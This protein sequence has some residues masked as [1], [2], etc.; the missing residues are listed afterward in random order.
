MKPC[1]YNLIRSEPFYRRD[2]FTAGLKACGFDVKNGQPNNGKPG[3]VLLIWNRYYQNHDLAVRFERDGGTV[4]VSENGYLGPS[5]I[6]P[7]QMQ[8]RCIYALAR[9]YHNDCT[10]I[11]SAGPERFNALGVTLQPWRTTGN[12]ILVCPNRSFGTPG[13]FMHP[14]WAAD[15]KKRLE[16]V[17]SREIRVRPHPGN[18]LP[19]KPLADDLKDCWAV[20]I[21][22]SSAGV[23]AL[24]AGI[25]VICEAPY[26][27]C[28]GAA[29][30]GFKEF[31][32]I[33]DIRNDYLSAY[34]GRL[35]ALQR[36]AHAQFNLSEIESGEAFRHIL[37]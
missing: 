3:D 16:R 31:E 2:A 26:W 37:Q 20:V 14:D 23:H 1:A 29:F 36:L 21:W 10:V 15:V 19:K 6:S 13:R 35:R 27:I 8:P 25:P 4:I 18:D 30:N 33:G 24:V 34:A 7:V 22:A 28:H 5:G 9:G 17:T 32:Q 12:H 11:P